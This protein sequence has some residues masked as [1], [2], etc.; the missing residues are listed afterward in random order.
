MQD[1]AIY[2]LSAGTY[3]ITIS[4]SNGC[5]Y[6]ENV[7]LINDEIGCDYYVYVPNLFSPNGDGNNDVIAV[8][9]KGVETLRFSI[10]NRWGNKVFET[11]DIQQGWNGEYK[12][13]AQ[14][15]AVFIYTLTGTFRN[16]ELFEFTG[17]VSLIR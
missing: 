16:G 10:Y 13:I 7:T 8:I 14:N 5:S 11:T 4:D 9:S 6:T 2:N 1:T 15:S 17:D 3:S 12:G